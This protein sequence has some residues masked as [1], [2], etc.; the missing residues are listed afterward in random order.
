M[1]TILDT[2]T[3]TDQV[4]SVLGI[5]DR[6]LADPEFDAPRVELELSMIMDANGIDYATVTTEGELASPSADQTKRYNYLK[7]YA[8]YSC[9]VLIIP[10]LR[11]AAT[12]KMADGANAMERFLKPEFAL[13]EEAF[14]G[15]AETYNIA[16]KE[17]ISGNVETVDVPS[18]FSGVA[19]TYDPVT[20]S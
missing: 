15:K 4:R 14:K 2:V 20:G 3:S 10:R 11:L 7:L 6:D 18:I 5:S 1:E 13:T 8:L 9:A 19:P 17:A 16:L 12:Q